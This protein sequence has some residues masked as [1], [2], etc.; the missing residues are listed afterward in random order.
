M[1]AGK[2][3]TVTETINGTAYTAQF[4]GIAVAAQLSDASVDKN[5]NFSLVQAAEFMLGN[6]LVEPAGLSLN[7]FDD[8]DTL[9]D[10]LHFCREVAAGNFRKKKDDGDA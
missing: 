8:M 2:F 3:Y 4:N 9:T 7:D 10:V 6:V 5:G 1:K